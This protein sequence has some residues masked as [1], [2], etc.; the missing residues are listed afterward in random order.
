MKNS[1]NS[2]FKILAA[3]FTGVAFYHLADLSFIANLPGDAIL[4]IAFSAAAIGLAIHDYSRSVRPV[5]VPCRV[6]RPS[7]PAARE[8]KPD[9]S[10][11]IAA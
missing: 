7:L 2:I 9:H 8:S 4:A 6:V 11:C 5:T 10:D 3:V 1:S